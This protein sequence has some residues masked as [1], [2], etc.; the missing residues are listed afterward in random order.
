[1]GKNGRI[2]LRFVKLPTINGLD[3]PKYKTLFG[4]VRFRPN[5]TLLRIT[6]IDHVPLEW[7]AYD[8]Q[9]G[10][11]GLYLEDSIREEATQEVMDDMI[12]D[13]NIAGLPQ[14]RG[15]KSVFQRRQRRQKVTVLDGHQM[16]LKP[17]Q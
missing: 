8:L 12:Q 1:M 14:V 13:I 7:E 4:T 9:D 10:L 6:Q 15:L 5:R 16:L 2:R 3:F 11:A 17:K